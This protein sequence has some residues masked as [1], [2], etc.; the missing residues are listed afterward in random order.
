MNKTKQAAEASGGTLV[1][2]GP[3]IRGVAQQWTC[4]T[5]GLT[6][7]LAALA[8]EDRAVAG[9]V[10]PLERLPDARK[11]IAYK[12]GRIYTLYTRVQAGLAE[13]AKAEKTRQ[14]V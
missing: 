9:L 4:Y 7:G 10:L 14:E 13:K 1:Y 12:Y 8:A 3:T 5:N 6:P 11:Q 2:C